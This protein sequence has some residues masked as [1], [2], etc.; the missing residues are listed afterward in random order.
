MSAFKD[1][2]SGHAAEYSAAR[3]TYPPALF[4][5]L[6]SLTTKHDHAVDVATGNGQAAAQLA[7]HYDRVTATDASEAQIREAEPHDHVEYLVRPAEALGLPDESADLLTV[8]Q[9]LHWFEHP[10]F[11]AE[12]TRV[13]R[14]GGV[15]AVWSYRLFEVSDAVDDAVLRFYTDVTGPYWPPERAHVDA[16]YQTLDFPLDPLDAKVPAMSLD[17]TVDQTLAYIGTWSGVKRY[18]TATGEP[19]LSRLEAPLGDAWGTST[20]TVLWPLTF[21][22]RRKP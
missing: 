3:P 22:A 2:F 5:V 13:L 12:A 7:R 14:P 8:A 6:A 18:A 16:S 17:W 21:V 19:P 20:R 9:A 15:L 1:H 11:F 4:D 10:A